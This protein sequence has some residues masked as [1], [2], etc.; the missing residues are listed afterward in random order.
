MAAL[1]SVLSTTDVNVKN[2]R[3][4]TVT[5]LLTDLSKPITF[6]TAMPSTNYRVFLTVESNAAQVL[7]PSAKTTSGFTLNA[8]IGVAGTIAWL[9]VED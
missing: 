9:V 6:G 5:L 3:S 1:G 4:G 2:L 7:W 8:S